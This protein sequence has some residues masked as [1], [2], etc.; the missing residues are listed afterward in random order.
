[1]SDNWYKVDNVAKVFLA[2]YN[3]RDTRSFRICCTLNEEI[4]PD[5]LQQA[6]DL[7]ISDMPQFQVLIHKGLFWHY[8]EETDQ[9]P[10]V[11]EET[12]RPCPILYGDSMS[13][14]LHYLVT[15][16]KNRINLEMFHAL[17]DGNGGLEFLNSIVLNYL[18]LSHPGEFD[19][20]SMRSGATSEDMLLDSFKHFY[21]TGSTKITSV[22]DAVKKEDKEK[23]AY[24]IKGMKLPDNQLQFFEIHMSAQKIIQAAKECKVGLT[25]FLGASLMMA[26]YQGMPALQKNKPITI[27]M[28]VNLRNYYPS[29]TIRNFF[30]SVYVSHT[31]SGS[32]TLEELAVLYDKEFKNQ[33]TPENIEKKM[34]NYMKLEKFFFVRMVPLAI[35][36]PVVKFFTKREYKS[37]TAVIS[38]MGKI[39]V[40]EQLQNYINSYAGTCSS[41]KLFITITCYGDDL[42]FGIASPYKNTGVLKRFIKSL[43]SKDIDVTVYA[44]NCH[45]TS[46]R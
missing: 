35:K 38:N 26:I 46:E 15:Y 41:E 17:T 31:F 4:K 7:S 3:D 19:D 22:L 32:E 34:Q 25:S 28:P 6:L 44:T 10:V 11:K 45:K 23:K 16:Y 27:S 30:N 2:T 40:P 18:Q 14:K 8:L 1:M 21:K 9:M 43:T 13:S 24:Q 33:L 5:I 36:N 42:T 39:K 37:V 12:D 29:E 20:L